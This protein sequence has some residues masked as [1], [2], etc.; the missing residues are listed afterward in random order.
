M[1]NKDAWMKT[2]ISSA[3]ALV[4]TLSSSAYSATSTQETEKCYGIVKA[5]LNDCQ[6][7]QAACAGS[8]TADNQSDAFL[9]LPK[10][11][12]EKIVGASLK[13]I[14]SSQKGSEGKK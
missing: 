11:A 7:A 14:T 2:S 5:G 9:L 8:S 13:P 12:C 6:T 1:K 4:C 3:L 10:G